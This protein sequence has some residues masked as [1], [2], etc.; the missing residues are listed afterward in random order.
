MDKIEEVMK[1]EADTYKK[2][3]EGIQISRRTEIETKDKKVAKVQ[4][5][6]GKKKDQTD[7]A[8]AF[9]QEKGF[10]A[11]LVLVPNPRGLL[12]GFSSV[13]AGCLVVCFVRH[14]GQ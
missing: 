4:Y 1:H 7:E 9:V 14:K 5:Y 3:Y 8:V 6:K 12:C 10:Y 13:L 2:Q 11:L